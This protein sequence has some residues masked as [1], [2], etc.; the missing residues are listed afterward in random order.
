MA[1][2][3]G[4]TSTEHVNVNE[5]NET[6]SCSWLVK[7][8]DREYNYPSRN[9]YHV[10]ILCCVTLFG[11]AANGSLIFI[12][13]KNR[14][15]RKTQ[16]ILFV[17][18]MIGDLVCLLVNV[19]IAIEFEIMQSNSNVSGNF[20]CK[21]RNF[22]MIMSACLVVYSLVALSIER[23]QKI[24]DPLGRNR[25][26]ESRAWGAFRSCSRHSN[27]LIV[28]VIWACSFAVAAPILVLAKEKNNRCSWIPHHTY[29]AKIFKMFRVMATFV[30]PFIIIATVHIIIACTLLRSIHDPIVK[31]SQIR[32]SLNGNGRHNS[33]KRLRDPRTT[34]RVKIVIVVTLLSTMF[35]LAQLP[36]TIFNMLFEFHFCLL[37]LKS[38]IVFY[39]WSTTPFYVLCCFNPVM[40]YILS[41]R[42]RKQL[43]LDCCFPCRSPILHRMSMSTRTTENVPLDNHTV[44]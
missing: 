36:I 14:H 39:R 19:P 7:I 38:F 42:F 43:M 25:W 10:S 15:L 35:F 41:S 11:F 27:V 3:P 5:N 28:L 37:W 1:T 40:M 21:F 9:L 18:L 4:F 6:D 23:Y 16:N 34:S 24:A 33:Q 20:I 8:E 44:K 31:D 13:L 26:G 29:Q 32:R 22:S 30:I 12:V 2:T 17:N